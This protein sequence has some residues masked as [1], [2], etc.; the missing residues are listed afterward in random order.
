MRSRLYAGSMGPTVKRCGGVGEFT[1]TFEMGW[2]RRR[3]LSCHLSPLNTVQMKT[4]LSVVSLRAFLPL[5]LFVSAPLASVVSAASDAPDVNV[6]MPSEGEALAD[7]FEKA[8]LKFSG[9]PIFLTYEKEGSSLRTLAGIRSV[10]A[11]GA[12]LII[13]TDK[14]STIAIPAKRVLVITDERPQTP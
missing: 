9:G 11:E 7:G 14:G 8:F 13:N 10:R 12:V 4:L 6:S 5:A 2:G 3:W 1:A